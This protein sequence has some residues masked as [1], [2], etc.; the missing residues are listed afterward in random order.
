MEKGAE[1]IRA[2]S[3]GPSNMGNLRLVGNAAS[4]DEAAIAIAAIGKTMVWI[5]FDVDAG[6]AER[7]INQSIARAIA[8]NAGFGGADGFGL[9][10]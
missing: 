3:N 6:M 4:K 7:R 9:G 2:L 5:D 10:C 1:V 8:G